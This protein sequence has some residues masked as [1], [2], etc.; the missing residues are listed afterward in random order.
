PNAPMRLLLAVHD[1]RVVGLISWTLTHELYSADTRVYI[2][3]VSVDYAYRGQGIG[4]ALMSE[5]TSW[6]LAHKATQLGWEVWHRNL[7][8]KAFYER[9]G[10]SID[11]EAIP[12]VLTLKDSS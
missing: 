8:A 11:Q 12:Y 9:F 7:S 6:A 10:A 4:T 2:S 5:V 1:D 3:D